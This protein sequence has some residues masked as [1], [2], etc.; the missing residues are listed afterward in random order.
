MYIID[1]II[2]KDFKNN[3]LFCRVKSMGGEYKYMSFKMKNSEELKN[4]NV[5][6]YI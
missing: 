4:I 1:S 5:G 2:S 6:N 3:I